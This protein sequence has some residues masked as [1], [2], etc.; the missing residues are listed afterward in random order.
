MVFLTYEGFDFRFTL[1]N[2]IVAS[3]LVG[4]RVQ[5][6]EP[7]ATSHAVAVIWRKSGDFHFSYWIIRRF[8]IPINA[9]WVSRIYLVGSKVYFVVLFA[10]RES[11]DVKIYFD[12]G[13][14]QKRL[15]G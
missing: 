9:A 4:P 6:S 3:L 1:T 15:A 14:G 11:H 10:K 13:A 2:S 5:S 12:G 8:F 7:L